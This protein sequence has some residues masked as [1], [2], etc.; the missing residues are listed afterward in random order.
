LR[1]SS[2]RWSC[3]GLSWVMYYERLISFT[4]LW[5]GYLD[6][7]CDIHFDFE[8]VMLGMIKYFDLTLFLISVVDGTFIVPVLWCWCSMEFRD[9]DWYNC[10]SE[11][12]DVCVSCDL[13][14]LS[15]NEL[16]ECRYC[17]LRLYYCHS[18]GCII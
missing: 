10:C 17:I 8:G 15:S 5:F 13:K 14:F 9:L 6:V 3:V 18:G 1:Q 4:L 2:R 7:G 12:R 16:Y 11:F